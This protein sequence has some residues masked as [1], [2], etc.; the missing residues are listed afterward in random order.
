MNVYFASTD[1]PLTGTCSPLKKSVEPNQGIQNPI[2]FLP[3]SEYPTPKVALSAFA[4]SSYTP[5][6]SICGPSPPKNTYGTPFSDFSSTPVQPVCESPRIAV[7]NPL[8]PPSQYSSPPTLL[9]I[10]ESPQISLPVSD[11]FNKPIDSCPNYGAHLF[12][13]DISQYKVEPTNSCIEPLYSGPS[14]SLSIPSMH[15]NTLMPIPAPDTSCLIGSD[16]T[17]QN[18]VLPPSTVE[19]PKFKAPFVSSTPICIPNIPS[20]LP[21]PAPITKPVTSE[22]N[23]P[24][25]IYDNTK[26][27]NNLAMSLSGVLQLYALNKFAQKLVT[28][29][30]ENS[31]VYSY[32]DKIPE[33]LNNI[34][35]YNPHLVPHISVAN[36]VDN[37]NSYNSIEEPVNFKPCNIWNTDTPLPCSYIE[38]TPKYL[39]YCDRNLIST[40]IHDISKTVTNPYYSTEINNPLPLYSS[41]NNNMYPMIYKNINL[42]PNTYV[43]SYTSELT[44]SINT[45]LPIQY[46]IKE[47]AIPKSVTYGNSNVISN[48]VTYVSPLSVETI[49]A[50]PLA[51]AESQYNFVDTN[52]MI[53]DVVSPILTNPLN[54]PQLSSVLSSDPFSSQFPISSC[55]ESNSLPMCLE[56]LMP[57]SIPVEL[58][59]VSDFP[60]SSGATLSIEP[61]DC[62][63]WEFV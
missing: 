5:A 1:T 62:S 11:T 55:V 10:F 21:I 53:C 45:N 24:P 31:N 26:Q 47:V 57:S 52:P 59:C 46:E 39:N 15:L 3:S 28:S 17:I 2:Q 51:L 19:N 22:V 23:V 29:P 34:D 40:N 25:V 8:N 42:H 9:P 33:S 20:V 63:Q 56:L 37:T 16:N 12:P 60:I 18:E 41:S 14:Y 58:V 43:D 7:S 6:V 32:S 44:N 27:D 36:G 13:S 38:S 48:D 4:D 54:V 50:L 61:L 30:C 49:E 35:N